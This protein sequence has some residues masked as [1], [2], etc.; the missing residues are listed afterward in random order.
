MKVFKL[1]W[2]LCAL[3][4]GFVSCDDDD[5]DNGMGNGGT[6]TVPQVA[7]S[8]EK[9]AM[10][11]LKNAGEVQVPI[12]LAEAPEGT[13]KLTIGVKEETG[14]VAAEGIDFDIKEKVIS[15]E[16]GN[17]IGYVTL[18]MLDN[19]KPETDRSFTLE[20]K[21]VYGYGKKADDKQTCEIAIVNNA[22]V[23][24]EKSTWMTWESAATN[25]E[26]KASCRVPL[27][28]TGTL[29]EAATIEINVLDSTAKEYQHFELASKRIT[30]N[31]GDAMAYVELIPIDDNEVNYDRL[32]SLAIA[33][34]DGSNL[35]IGKAN[36]TC[37]VTVVSEEKVKTVSFKEISIDLG[38]GETKAIEINLDNPPMDGEESVTVVLAQKMGGNAEM[39]VDYNLSTKNVVF[40]LG[41]RVKYVDIIS[42]NDDEIFDRK[43]V[44]EL[45]APVGAV[46]D[47][48]RGE[49]EVN[50]KNDDYPYFKS[51]SYASNEGTGTN[52][53]PICIPKVLEHDVT[54]NI[55]LIPKE[56][57]EGTDYKL[58]SQTVT[59][60]AG[61]TEANIEIWL[62]YSTDYVQAS[63]D[64]VVTGPYETVYTP[65]VKTSLKMKENNYRKFFGKYNVAYTP[66]AGEFPSGVCTLQISAD[67]EHFMEYLICKST[68]YISGRTYT[69]RLK[70]N[71]WDNSLAVVHKETVF[72]N[73]GFSGNYGTC[74]I[75]LE[76]VKD[77]NADIPV[78]INE[79]LKVLTWDLQGSSVEGILYKA[80][81]DSRFSVRWFNIESFVMTR[82]D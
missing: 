42:V 57:K 61:K 20:I 4:V 25:E 18:V 44:L 19:G 16:K 56:G 24:F 2:I 26:Y 22:F 27:K 21:N 51:A 70:F 64:L 49:I 38:E 31:P 58:V 15:I 1:L 8:F 65:E 79:D 73:V 75:K 45:K 81:D 3:S 40:N 53:L 76:W 6:G 55:T 12:V 10:S 32:F 41:E 80:S 63:F 5:D 36:N 28:I 9:G 82:A 47:S 34:V 52:Y 33:A 78:K 39:D 29:R 7:V 50:V 17:K 67:P 69:Q 77:R 48:E 62:G 37:E 66:K 74:N 60:P 13:V 11:V 43:F 14:T 68:D 54:V 30:V 59:I 46:L 23:E 72:P 35:S 71:A